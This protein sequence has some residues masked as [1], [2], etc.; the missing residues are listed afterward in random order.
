M[1]D[2]QQRVIDEK[3]Q[4]DDKIKKLA[5]FDWDDRSKVSKDESVLLAN[6]LFFMTEY[7]RVLNDRILKF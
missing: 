2:Y 3:S 1:E 7:S 4:L 5:T 6:Q